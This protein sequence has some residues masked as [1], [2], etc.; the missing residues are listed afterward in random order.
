MGASGDMLMGA[1]FELLPEQ[2]L[3]LQR[4]NSLGL[5]GVSVTAEPMTKCGLDGTK[6]RVI[7]NGVEETS[8]DMPDPVSDSSHASHKH[9]NQP[10]KKQDDSGAP[11][12]HRH[13]SYTDICTLILGLDLAEN[14]KTQAL[15][16]YRLL[17]ET[18]SAVHNEPLEALSFHEVGS[19]DAVADIV[20]CCLLFHMLGPMT[21]TASPVHVGAGFIR[22][23]HGVL[24][25]PAPATAALLKDIPIYGGSIKAELCTPTGAA[26]LRHFVSRFGEME[27]MAVSKI[28]CGMGTKDF[29]R[30]NCLRAFLSDRTAS[31]D[32]VVEISCNLDD[33]TPEALGYATT[34]LM[35]NGALDVFTTPIFMKKN[36]PAVLLTCL[37]RPEEKD[38]LTQ[39]ILEQTTTFG[40]RL[41]T[42]RRDVLDVTLETVETPYGSVLVKTGGGYGVTKSKP[43]YEDVR[44]CA[45]RHGVSFQTVYNAVMAVIAP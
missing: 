33:M 19:L 39:A 45:D 40:V 22:C 5:P 38:I 30:P 44:A 4:M 16:V 32:T 35:D 17:G 11:A 36:R 7:V 10:V 8:E 2:S 14:V 15:D 29:D 3:F 41:M 6:I 20:G 9:K 27:P 1:L 31:T 12:P 26:L 13:Y 24:P 21:V 37:C 18:E 43:E 25:V 42:R 28:G 23:A 34:Y